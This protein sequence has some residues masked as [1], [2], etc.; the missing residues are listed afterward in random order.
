MDTL[1]NDIVPI[2][3]F[4]SIPVTITGDYLTY[5]GVIKIGGPF[6]TEELFKEYISTI[7]SLEN[8]FLTSLKD[9]LINATPKEVKEHLVKLGWEG[10]DYT[11]YSLRNFGTNVLKDQV[12]TNTRQVIELFGDTFR[13]QY[14]CAASKKR[15]K[16]H[17]DNLNC[18]IHGFKIHIPINVKYHVF[19]KNAKNN[20]FDIYVLEP[21]YAYYLN[22]CL[23]HFVANPYNETRVNLSFQ[24]ASDILIKNGTT[25]TPIAQLQNEEDENEIYTIF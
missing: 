7:K 3:D 9:I 1:T 19:V 13:Q 11:S 18:E 12:Q 15:L 23:T 16:P 14:M 2:G 20:K 4:E 21:G 17:I 6:N 5:P 24:L 25:I 8:N 10:N 22:S